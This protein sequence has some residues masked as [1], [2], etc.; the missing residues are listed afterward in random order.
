LERGPITTIEKK[1]LNL[2]KGQTKVIMREERQTLKKNKNNK[3]D[4]K[5]LISKAHNMGQPP[6][7]EY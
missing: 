5:I 3:E 1:V 6:P 2:Q 4:K 7:Q